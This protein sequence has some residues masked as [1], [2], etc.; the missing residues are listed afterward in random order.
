VLLQLRAY[1]PQRTQYSMCTARLNKAAELRALETQQ[2]SWIF[3]ITHRSLH[4]FL[5]IRP[6]SGSGV[7]GDR[8]CQRQVKCASK[9]TPARQQEAT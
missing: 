4:D 5:G 9:Q 1:M 8:G 7:A 6:S 2:H 3:I